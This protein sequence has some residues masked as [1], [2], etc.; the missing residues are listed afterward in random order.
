MGNSHWDGR[1]ARTWR[2]GAGFT[3]LAI[4]FPTRSKRAKNCMKMQKFFV[5][6]V[7][8]SGATLLE[9]VIVLSA[10]RLES[11]T[12]N[13]T[14]GPEAAIS[15]TCGKVCDWNYSP[16]LLPVIAKTPPFCCDVNCISS[17]LAAVLQRAWKFFKRFSFV[18]RRIYTCKDLWL[19]LQSF[20]IFKFH[21]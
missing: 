20:W 1:K 14:L 12:T 13:D 5:C 2:R 3:R 6:F 8:K 18:S 9:G 17:S 21:S 16:P 4:W 11:S 19:L 7:E 10:R 15:F